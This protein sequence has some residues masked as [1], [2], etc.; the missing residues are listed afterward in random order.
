MTPITP[1][2][3][4][5]KLVDAHERKVMA[6]DWPLPADAMNYVLPLGAFTAL[7]SYIRTLEKENAQLKE[8]LKEADRLIDPRY[9]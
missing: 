4:M 1:E 2:A 7:L 3:E 8:D 9:G 5:Q 6:N